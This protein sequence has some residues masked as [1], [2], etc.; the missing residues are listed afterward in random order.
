MGAPRR[1]RHESTSPIHLHD[2]PSQRE[3]RDTAPISK[4]LNEGPSPGKKK[5]DG[6]SWRQ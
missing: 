2:G 4:G 1:P 6:P 5:D 3:Q